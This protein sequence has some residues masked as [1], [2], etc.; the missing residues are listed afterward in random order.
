MIM[1]T[2][3]MHITDYVHHGTAAETPQ[4]AARTVLHAIALRLRHM[5]NRFLHEHALR[6]AE[7]ELMKLDDRMLRDI[8]LSRSEVASAVR[9]PEQERINGAGHPVSCPH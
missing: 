4:H 7:Q 2:Q 6:R 8:G 3:R 1:S 5:L 9:N